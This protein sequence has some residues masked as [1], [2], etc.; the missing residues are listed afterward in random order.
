MPENVNTSPLGDVVEQDSEL[1]T[2]PVMVDVSHVSMVF[3]L[4]L[5]HI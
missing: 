4:S 5:I 3:N 1:D 2:R